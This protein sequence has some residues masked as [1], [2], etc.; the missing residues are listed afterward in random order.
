MWTFNQR[1]AKGASRARSPQEPIGSWYDCEQGMRH[2]VHVRQQLDHERQT[3]NNSDS[4]GDSR[5]FT[6]H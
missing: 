2:K 3:I 4:W 6:R 1:R 5:P